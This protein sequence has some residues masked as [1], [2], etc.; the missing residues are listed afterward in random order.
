MFQHL[1]IPQRTSEDLRQNQ[2]VMKNTIGQPLLH[3]KLLHNLVTNTKI[4]CCVSSSADTS[5]AWLILGGLTYWFGVCAQCMAS[6]PCLV[7]GC[8]WLRGWGNLAFHLTSS[9][10]PFIHSHPEA[11]ASSCGGGRVPRG[12]AG[13]CNA[14]LGL[15]Q[16]WH[17]ISSV[18]FYWTKH[19]GHPGFKEW[20][21]SLHSS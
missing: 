21:R 19:P 17:G 9:S 16:N 20:R 14:F 11:L 8:S 13:V 1:F 7:I 6:L 4:V 10:R 18:M 12:K 5:Q 2:N 3:D 15:H